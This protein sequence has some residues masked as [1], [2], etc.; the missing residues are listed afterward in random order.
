MSQLNDFT[1]EVI[2]KQLDNLPPLFPGSA[3]PIDSGVLLI[4][5]LATLI[6]STVLVKR[7]KNQVPQE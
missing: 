2:A 4:V 7:I 5:V 3:N 1:Q 6:V